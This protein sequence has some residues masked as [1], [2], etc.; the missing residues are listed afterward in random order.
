MLI[1]MFIAWQETL[2]L[3]GVITPFLYSIYH[4][5]TNG[6]LNAIKKSLWILALIFGSF[7]GLITYWFYGRHGY[8]SVSNNEKIKSG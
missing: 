7:I 5:L 6:K 4:V 3:I 2:L 8:N 1:K